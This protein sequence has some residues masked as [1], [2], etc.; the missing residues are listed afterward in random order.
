M[1]TQQVMTLLYN[2]IHDFFIFDCY[3]HHDPKPSELALPLSD[4]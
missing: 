2:I 1:A 3:N 4:Q